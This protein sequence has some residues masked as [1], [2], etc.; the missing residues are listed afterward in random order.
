LVLA[1]SLIAYAGAILVK[2]IAQAL[3][4]GPFTS[5]VGGNAAYLGLYYGLQTVF[6][7]VGGAYLVAC[8]AFSKGKIRA[9]DAEGYGIGLAFWENGVLVGG[10]LL[11]NYV[12]YDVLLFGGGTV[13]QQFYTSLSQI[14]P[15]LFNPPSGALPLVGFAI[16][17]R[18][19][20]LLSH[21]SWGL[22]CVLAVTLRKKI[23]LWLA[24]P[25]GLVDFL[26]PFA[27]Q[28]GLPAFEALNFVLSLASLGVALGTTIRV[29]ATAASTGSTTV[30]TINN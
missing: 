10:S 15:S 26:V 24:L 29:R 22:L 21:F 11:L 17:E 27:G 3:T 23:Y 12:I 4:V 28:L 5:A 20:S 6:F 9:E 1:L 30:G 16:L 25:M 2:V 18:V 7:E 14:A 19:S 8:Y 13:A